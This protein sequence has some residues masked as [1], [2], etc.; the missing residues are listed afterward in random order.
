MAPKLRRYALDEVKSRWATLLPEHRQAFTSFEDPFLVERI[1]CALQALFEKQMVMSHLGLQLGDDADPFASSTLFT[2]AFEFTWNISRS[3]NNPAV[4]LVDPASM[5]VMAM[6]LPF[7][8]SVDFFADL[9]CVLPDFL[10]LRSGRVP[11]PRAR[12]KEIWAVE[13]SSVSGMEQSLVRLVEQALWNMM[14]KPACNLA[15]AE[16]PAPEQQAE[17]PL[18]AWMIEDERPKGA[19]KK[20]KLQK[21][22]QRP[23][24]ALETFFEEG[25]GFDRPGCCTPAAE[26]A[27]DMTSERCAQDD[28]AASDDD[29]SVNTVVRQPSEDFSR[30]EDFGAAGSDADESV[31][32]GTFHVDGQSLDGSRDPTASS[33]PALG[34]GRG[35]RAPKAYELPATPTSSKLAPPELVCYIWTQ[36]AQFGQQDSE[37][38]PVPTQEPASPTASAAAPVAF[39]RG[40]WLGLGSP[41]ARTPASACRTPK[42]VVR[43]TFV[44]IDDP[45]DGRPRAAVRCSRSL[46]PMRRCTSPD[47]VWYHDNVNHFHG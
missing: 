45:D 42:V 27:D 16:A 30:C 13:P 23:P 24:R 29:A 33:T 41:S 34:P 14:S 9:Q 2:T 40:H 28:G 46:S 1:K 38:V 18:E 11:L 20:K 4:C 10:S 39:S 5:P 19:S 36:T 44:D 7:L 47:D 26:D 17:V 35:H 37:A 22:R 6:K 31:C 15:I 32:M 8:Q 25:L 21:Q 12:W 43:N 3:R